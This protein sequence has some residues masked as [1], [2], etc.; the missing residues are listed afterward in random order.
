MSKLKALI[1]MLV[2][3]ASSTAMASPS[4]TFTAGGQ[5]SWGS[6]REPVRAPIIRDHRTPTP[7]RRPV[8][9]RE[10][11]WDDRSDYRSDYRSEWMMLGTVAYERSLEH[12]PLVFDL[13]YTKVAR[14]VLQSN[15]GK[16]RVF[17]VTFQFADGTSE[18]IQLDRYVGEK[19]TVDLPASPSLT[20]E[21]SRCAP[22]SRIIINGRPAIGSS[23]SVLISER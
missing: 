20:I 3:G 9:F 10:V 15:G 13:R 17:D 5:V 12:Q 6:Y 14:L 7:P 2:V 8:R 11:R 18:V 21:P 19:G 4:F 16:A 1:V 23:Y 22:V